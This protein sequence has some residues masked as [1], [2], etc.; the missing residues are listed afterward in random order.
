MG[1]PLFGINISGLIKKFI[2]PGVLA[3][4]LIKVTVGTRTNGALTSGTNPTPAS[5]SCRGFIDRQGKRRIPGG[6][7][8][9][10]IV[11]V[12]LIGDTIENGTVVP[13]TDDQI[14]IEGRTFQIA[15]PIDR[16]PAA[17]TYACPCTE[18]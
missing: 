8:K 15:G 13:E 4:T 9:S 17:A 2:A 5:Y 6:L 1:Q 3:A 10:R 12:L 11:W 18:R 16:D 7:E 14:T